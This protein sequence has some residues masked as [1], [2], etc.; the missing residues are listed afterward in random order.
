MPIYV[1]DGIFI[2]EEVAG[3]TAGVNSPRIGIQNISNRANIYASTNELPTNPS[4]LTSTPSTAERWKQSE[5]TTH[6]W[7]MSNVSSSPVD[8]VGIAAHR[9]LIGRQVEV[10]AVID[11]VLTTV[12]G[13][14]LILSSDSIFVFFPECTPTIV[15]AVFES[16]E[17]FSFE[18]G[19]INVGKTVFL[20]RN[21]YV[22]HTPITYGRSARRLFAA[23][24]SDEFLG[25]KLTGVSLTSSVNME[26]IPPVFYRDYLFNQFHV[27]SEYLPF[28]WAWRPNSY[29][30]ESGF[31]WLSG[32][33]SVSNA[34]SNGFMSLAFSMRGYGNAQ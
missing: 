11:G 17:A 29:P 32:D 23:S 24:D 19:I 9:G 15:Y 30:L 12:F 16:D 13:P 25:Q 3:I 6:I 1:S 2:P 20:P 4:Y 28:F 7:A 34:K 22:G 27:P 8:Y 31:C 21:I 10:R 18:I 5:A 26:N 33:I 14:Q